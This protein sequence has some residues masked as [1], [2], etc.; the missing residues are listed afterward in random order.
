MCADVCARQQYSTQQL[1]VASMALI[2]AVMPLVH[3][4]H[5]LPI[6]L[7][8]HNNKLNYFTICLCLS[9]LEVPRGYEQT[10]GRHR[11]RGGSLL[12]FFNMAV[13]DALLIRL[14][15]IHPH[16]SCSSFQDG[17]HTHHYFYICP[18]FTQPSSQDNLHTHHH[19][20]PIISS[21]PL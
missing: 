19:F 6:M 11:V 14:F 7:T 1:G 15:V 4:R 21:L 18:H 13:P 12:L 5:M 8:V 9:D 16:F 2:A 20:H 17:H 3:C 10:Q